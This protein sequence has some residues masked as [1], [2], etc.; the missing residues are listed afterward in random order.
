[1]HVEALSRG[2]GWLDSGTHDSL[3]EAS[4]YIKAVEKRQGLKVACLEE[5]A[6][7]NKWINKKDIIKSIQFYGNCEYSFYL[8]KLIS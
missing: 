7:L 8:K 3:I 4:Q 6:L 2:F 5:I 1:M